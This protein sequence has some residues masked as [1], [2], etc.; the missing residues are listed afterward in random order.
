MSWKQNSGRL[1]ATLFLT[2]GVLLTGSGAFVARAA[3]VAQED[4]QALSEQGLV[5]V[6]VV[7]E[8]PAATAGVVRGD[9]LLAVDDEAVESVAGLRDLL[10]TLTPENEISATVLH[11]DEQRTLTV[12]LGERDGRA[13]LGIV[14]YADPNLERNFSERNSRGTLPP[15]RQTIP[16][17]PSPPNFELPDAIQPLSEGALVQAV[18]PDSAADEAGLVEGDIILSVDGEPVNRE[19]D[20]A[21][22]LGEYAPG[23]EIEL[24]VQ[25]ANDAVETLNVTLGEHPDDATR[26]FL[27]I[28]YAPPMTRFFGQPGQPGGDTSDPLPSGAIIGRVAPDSAAAEAGLH[29]GD[30]IVEVEGKAIKTPQDLIE[31][32]GDMSPGDEITLLVEGM[33]G[34]TFEVTVVLGKS[35]EGGPQ[36]GVVLLNNTPP[37]EG[38]VAPGE[39]DSSQGFFRSLPDGF[40]LPDI[41]GK[42]PG[43]ELPAPEGDGSL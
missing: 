5:I 18:L 1:I 9:I 24:A 30:R 7:G 6:H 26:P 16:A 41:F 28:Q 15:P 23:D 43:F 12:T 4:A 32:V 37:A 31:Q 8:G 11:G 14:P 21:E 22:L 2:L 29:P 38:E 13:Y 39:G 27:G 35:E 33:D 19:N 20:L 34:M 10:R 40:S 3:P 42:L 17:P 25:R 36:L